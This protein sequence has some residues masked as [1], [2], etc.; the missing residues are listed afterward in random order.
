MPRGQRATLARV[1]PAHRRGRGRDR[2]GQRLRLRL[3]RGGPQALGRARLGDR[4]EQ[5]ASP[6]W[7]AWS[8]GAGW[9]TAGGGGRPSRW[10]SWRRPRR[11]P[12]PTAGGVTDFT[13]G[14]MVG[15]LRRGRAR[16]GGDRPLHRDLPP[17]RP[18]DR[19]GLGGRRGGR[20]RDRGP[21]A[22]RV[23]RRRR[24]RDRAGLAAR[25]RAGDLPAAHAARRPPGAACPRARASSSA[26]R[27]RRRR[28]GRGGRCRRRATPPATLATGRARAGG[29]SG[30]A[31]GARARCARA[32]ASASPAGRR[33]AAVASE[34]KSPPRM[35]GSVGSRAATISRTRRYW[36]YEPWLRCAPCTAST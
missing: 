4:R 25:R 15:R 8:W 27:A 2:P 35:I 6:A 5:R 11:R 1:V 33:A 19:A 32:P 20:R 10:G 14:Y 13:V 23:R 7:P 21:G 29:R 26:S 31:G 9:P 3:R 12:S 36:R 30:S 22:L 28:R 16:P 18:G 17:R 24:A 34:L